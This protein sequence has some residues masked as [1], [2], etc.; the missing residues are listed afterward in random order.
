M[1]VP[2]PGKYTAT[3][4]A[5]QYEFTIESANPDIG[6]IRGTYQTNNS[7]IGEFEAALGEYDDTGIQPERSSSYSWVARVEG[8]VRIN[9]PPFLIRIVATAHRTDGDKFKKCQHTWTGIYFSDDTI[10]MNGTECYLE[11]D[12]E[13]NPTKETDA[14][15]IAV[16]TFKLS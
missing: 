15:D 2:K 14:F 6:D 5:A 8:G 3:S 12:A 11:L 4:D 1:S 13:G 10:R 7:R 16:L 9:Q